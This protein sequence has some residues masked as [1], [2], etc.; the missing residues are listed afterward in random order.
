MYIEPNHK[1]QFDAHVQSLT[2]R[3]KDS[4]KHPLG[5]LAFSEKELDGGFDF[6]ATLND[7]T[8]VSVRVW[9][10]SVDVKA[11]TGH[12][13][14]EQAEEVRVYFDT[15]YPQL[16]GW[17]TVFDATTMS[18]M[19]AELIANGLMTPYGIYHGDGTFTS[20]STGKRVTIPAQGG[21]FAPRGAGRSVKRNKRMIY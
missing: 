2:G 21:A 17:V 10:S 18:K 19:E 13:N 4:S 8:E 15:G 12:L 11:K 20:Y 1:D 16:K 14:D 6:P 9:L 5:A 3:L 7:G